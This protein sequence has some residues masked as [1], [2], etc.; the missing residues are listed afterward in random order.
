MR[1]VEEVGQR[2]TDTGPRSCAG[3]CGCPMSI[4]ATTA[5]VI[6]GNSARSS[7]IATPA[8]S[9]PARRAD[10]PYSAD[11]RCRASPAPP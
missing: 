7:S 10:S 3:T 5:T 1:R 4:R 8:A 6:G 2:P 9:F 11:I